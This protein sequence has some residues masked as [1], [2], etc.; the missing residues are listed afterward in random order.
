[1]NIHDGE[2][3]E[4]K[5]PERRIRQSFSQRLL[6]CWITFCVPPL[7]EMSDPP[8]N[9]F[10]GWF[11]FLGLLAT[12]LGLLGGSIWW[13]ADGSYADSYH[14]ARGVVMEGIQNPLFLAGI[15]LFGILYALTI[16]PWKAKKLT[17]EGKEKAPRRETL[18]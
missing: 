5:D 18:R 6:Y 15:G 8:K 11:R 17:G 7:P 4:L 16:R 14:I 1:M 2:Q 13:I 9:T 10:F 3:P 12:S